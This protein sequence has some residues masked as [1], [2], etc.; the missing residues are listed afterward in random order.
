MLFAFCSVAPLF[1]LMLPIGIPIAIVFILLAGLYAFS[2]VRLEEAKEER[3][4]RGFETIK[5]Q[6]GNVYSRLNAPKEDEII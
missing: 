1:F 4:V 6:L 5:E 3:D 2:W